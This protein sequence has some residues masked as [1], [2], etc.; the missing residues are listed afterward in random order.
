MDNA[1][2]FCQLDGGQKGQEVRLFTL[3]DEA[4]KTQFEH[5]AICKFWADLTYTGKTSNVVAAGTNNLLQKFGHLNKLING[6]TSNSGAGTPE[7]YANACTKIGIWHQQGMSNSCSLHDLQSVFWLAMQQFVGEGGLDAQN[8]LQL[9]HAIFSL[10][11]E[12]K[13]RW[14]RVV[15]LVWKG[16][17]TNEQIPDN[18]LNSV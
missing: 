14:K 7:S 8:A 3:L 11:K 16:M 10:Y 13:S 4:D 2:V 5:W 1:N 17:H 15:S 18:L 12:L 6:S 9:L